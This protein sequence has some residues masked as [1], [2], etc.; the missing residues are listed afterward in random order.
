MIA[1]IKHNKN[2]FDVTVTLFRKIVRSFLP[3]ANQ[4]FSGKSKAIKAMG[5]NM[6]TA[7]LVSANF[8]SHCLHKEERNKNSCEIIDREVYQD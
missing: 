1:I 3:T 6:K 5:C 2:A 7:I 4:C 8:T